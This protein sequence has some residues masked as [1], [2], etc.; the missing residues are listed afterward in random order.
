MRTNHIIITTSARK[1]LLM[2]S[3]TFKVWGENNFPS[4]W[5]QHIRSIESLCCKT[6]IHVQVGWQHDRGMPLSTNMLFFCT[7][8]DD[9]GR[10]YGVTNKDPKAYF[11]WPGCYLC[12]PK[13]VQI[14][15][16]LAQ[17]MLIEPS[18]S[19][20]EAFNASFIEV[21]I[22]DWEMYLQIRPKM[23]YLY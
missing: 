11:N 8:K 5:G 10:H 9:D 20:S 18:M 16:A 17:E 2:I 3:L 23:K 12:D 6:H 7:W 13:Y 15:A 22:E 1:L 4:C 14:N 21:E 19:I